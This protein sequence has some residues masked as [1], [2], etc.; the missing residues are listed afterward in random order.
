[1]TK[2]ASAEGLWFTQTTLF[3]DQA[4][5]ESIVAAIQKVK[6]AWA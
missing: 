1:V 6:Q 3:G 4:D 5:T 2:R